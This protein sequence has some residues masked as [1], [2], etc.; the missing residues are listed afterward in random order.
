MPLACQVT[1]SQ[2]KI[3]VWGDMIH[4]IS[5]TLKRLQDAKENLRKFE[6]VKQS[7]VKDTDDLAIEDLVGSKGFAQ[8]IRTIEPI[9]KVFILINGDMKP[10]MCYLQ[11]SFLTAKKGI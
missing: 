7:R 9:L 5:L 10:C 1:S 3:E 8:S 2:W 11:S 4:P 6:W